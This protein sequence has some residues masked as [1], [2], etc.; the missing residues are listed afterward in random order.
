MI[1]VCALLLEDRETWQRFCK[2]MFNYTF[3]KTPFAM[4][5]ALM[6]LPVLF[7]GWT[8]VMTHF[9][10]SNHH[11]RSNANSIAFNIPNANTDFALY[12]NQPNPF[13]RQTAISFVLPQRQKIA[14]IIMDMIGKIISRTEYT[15]DTGYQEIL[16]DDINIRGVLYYQLRTED[17][18]LAT[19]RMI[20]E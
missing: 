20:A 9:I 3:E 5:K 2:Y 13:K 16:I 19:R 10:T 4:H 12:Q 1:F 8:C 18:M 6:T 15:L 14:L 7:A 17:G 11:H